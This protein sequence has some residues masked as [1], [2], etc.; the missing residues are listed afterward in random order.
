MLTLL[1][2]TTAGAQSYPTGPV[3]IIVPFGAGGATDVLARVF[4]DQLQQRLGQ[5]FTP[6]NRGGAAGQIAATAVARSPA[7][8]STLMF[9]TAAPITIAP[10]MNDKVQYDPRKDFVTIAVVAVMPVWLVVNANSPLQSAADIVA[11]AKANPGKLNYGTS[12][13]GTELHLAAEALSR[14]AGIQ[15]QH[16][17]FRGGGEVIAALLGNQLD[18]AALSTASIAGALKQGSL[19]ALAVSSPQRMSDFP[20]VPTFAEIGHPGATMMPWWGLMAPAGT[21]KPIV[22]RLT[23]E[24]EAATKSEPVRERLKATFVQIDFAG[25]QEFARRLEAETALYGEII[26]AA[27]IKLD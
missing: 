10:L 24:L 9:T 21:P 15:M 4:A 19:R 12:G 3:K 26:R 11:K 5:P 27:K 1:E 16:V 13:V 6:E 20:D 22:A 23:Q 25:P 17:P 14:S 2:V 18:F 8:G 7:D